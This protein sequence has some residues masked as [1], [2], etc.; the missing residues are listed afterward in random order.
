MDI[1]AIFLIVASFASLLAVVE[2]LDRV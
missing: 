1:F 2:F